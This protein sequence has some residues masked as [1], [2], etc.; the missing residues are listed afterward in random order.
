MKKIL[1]LILMVSFATGVHAQQAGFGVK[2][3]YANITAKAKYQ[4]VTASA[5]ESGFYVGI[6]KEI[7]LGDS[8]ILQPELL[9]AN[10]A[11]TGFL[12]LPIMAKY[13]VS[14]QFSL[15]A[16]PQANFV[17]DSAPEENK[18]GLDIAFGAGFNIDSHFFIDARYG[19]EVTNRMGEE[20]DGYDIKGSY[21]TLMVGVGYKF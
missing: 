7:P 20:Y 6:L 13:N 11:E 12:Y 18:F 14:P 19:L 5:S 21:N 15:Q 8:F 10:A 3:G 1:L 17:L 9:Y 16:G 2:A 4:G